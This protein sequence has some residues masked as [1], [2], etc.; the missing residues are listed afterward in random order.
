MKKR[1]LSHIEVVLGFLIFL[2][3]IMFIIASYEPLF[4][5]NNLDQGLANRLYDG[6][7]ENTSIEVKTY[8][9]LITSNTNMGLYLGEDLTNVGVIALNYKGEK[10]SLGNNGDNV[11]LNVTKNYENETIRIIISEDIDK[12]TINCNN[13]SLKYNITT[14]IKEIYLDEEKI[15]IFNNT[16]HNN[17]RQLLSSIS[18]PSDSNFEYNITIYN[19]KEYTG[20][21]KEDLRRMDVFTSKRR[22][23]IINSS[24]EVVEGE[25]T[26]RIW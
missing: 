24:N 17:L 26:F 8:Y 11:C 21:T 3:S 14:M 18:L 7:F 10:I 2:V 15:K 1:G 23:K 20:K 4:G 19:S 6:F 25:A 12:T 5:K 16:Y 13:D 22:L 9:A